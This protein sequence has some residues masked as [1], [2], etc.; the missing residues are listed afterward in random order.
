MNIDAN[1]DIGLT[2]PRDLV[3]PSRDFVQA[4]RVW[5]IHRFH[6]NLDKYL[7]NAAGYGN[8]YGQ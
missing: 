1:I 4:N 2:F 3:G 5:T 6:N 8:F 7:P